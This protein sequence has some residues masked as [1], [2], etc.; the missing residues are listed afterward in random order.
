[1]FFYIDRV[2]QIIKPKKL[3]YLAVD[4]V[5]PRAKLNQ[6]RSR[7]FASA[8]D[9]EAELKSLE[10]QGKQF[11]RDKIFDSNVITPGTP[12][13]ARVSL[14]FQYFIRKK[15]KEDPLW[16]RLKVIYSGY[17][18]P[19]EGEHKIIEYIRVEKMSPTH[20]PNTRHVMYGL[21]ADL[22]MLALL[23]HEPHFALLREQVDFQAFRRGPRATKQLTKKLQKTKWQLLHISTLREYL[24]LEFSSVRA[25]I[26]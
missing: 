5:A 6:Q 17:E 8:R 11:D 23:S 12:F 24:D 3:L 9:R 4:G 19:G 1:M 20:D 26:K 2:V 16:Q 18:V 13:M 10:E 15:I 14:H 22:I 7:R 25:A 21:D